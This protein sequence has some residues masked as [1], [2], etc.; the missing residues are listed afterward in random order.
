MVHGMLCRPIYVKE[1]DSK[2]DDANINLNGNQ[3]E[4]T[5]NFDMGKNKYILL[6]KHQCT[7]IRNFKF[8]NNQLKLSK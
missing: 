6:F 5:V 1:E 3:R 8:V 7:Q 4:H 2:V